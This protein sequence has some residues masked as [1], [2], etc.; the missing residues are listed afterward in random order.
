MHFVKATQNYSLLEDFIKPYEAFC[1]QLA[2]Y[3]RK[4]SDN[5]Y[6]LCDEQ[7]P[8]SEKNIYGVIYFKSTLLHCIPDYSKNESLINAALTDFLADKTIKCINGEREN[9]EKIKNLLKTDIKP[10]SNYYKLLIIDDYSQLMPPQE[11]LSCDDEI[12]RATINNLD[13]LL[14]LQKNYVQEEVAPPGKQVEDLEVKIILK[15]ILKN[16]VCVVLKSDT[17]PV[18]KANTNAIG[19]NYVQIGGVYTHP[20]YRRNSYGWHLVYNLCHRILKTKRKA[21]LYVK[22]KNIPALSLYD[23]IG[24]TQ[25]GDFE[26]AYY[27]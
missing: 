24:F 18:A 26:I 15:Q 8:L 17:V 4:E 27:F 14:E 9:T 11:K 13:E 3:I 16:Q 2:S 6:A 21:V 7:H 22:E 12:H 19:W 23:K 25:I 10:L 1:I 5:L 20:A